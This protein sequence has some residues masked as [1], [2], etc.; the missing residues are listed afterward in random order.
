MD[1]RIHEERGAGEGTIVPKGQVV[2]FWPLT[3]SNR[4]YLTIGKDCRSVLFC[5][6]R[7]DS[8]VLKLTNKVKRR[9][10]EG[11][12]EE[13]EGKVEEG[14]RRGKGGRGEGEVRVRERRGEKRG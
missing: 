2:P 8:I 13:R 9:E 1:I 11:R 5:Y 7:S 3:D 4:L 6:K 14:E 10:R 12:G